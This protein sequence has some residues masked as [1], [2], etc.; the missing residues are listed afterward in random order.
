MTIEVKE[1]AG[2]GILHLEGELG[3]EEGTQ[4][5]E[6]AGDALVGRGARA[7]IEMSGVSY[8]SSAGISALV[9]VVGQANTQEQSVVLAGPTPLVAGVFAATRLDKFFTIFSSVDEAVRSMPA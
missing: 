5:V 4:L 1:Q 7:I 6:A 9:R 3:L 8:L 2:I